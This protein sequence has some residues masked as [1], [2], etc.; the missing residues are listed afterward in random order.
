MIDRNLFVMFVGL[1]IAG[2]VLF[3]I[4]FLSGSA[5]EPTNHK[6]VLRWILVNFGSYYGVIS[7][8]TSVGG[9]M[10]LAKMMGDS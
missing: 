1:N 2:G 3:G 4:G 5:P 7:W 8:G 6:A 9:L 10:W